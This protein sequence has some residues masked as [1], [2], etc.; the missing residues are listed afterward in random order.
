MALVHKE[1]RF[2]QHQDCCCQCPSHYGRPVLTQSSAGDPHTLTGKSGSVFC[3]VTVP[4]PS[5]LV[6]TGFAC[7]LQ[8]WSLFLLVLWSSYNQ[9][10]LAFKV[11]FP[12]DSQYL[13]WIPH[14]GSLMWGLEPSRQCEDFFGFIV[15]RFVGHPLSGYSVIA[16]R[17]GKQTH[18]E[19]QCR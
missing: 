12:W 9:V 15:L 16:T 11:R 8:E 7:V 6:H 1:P 10:P 14:L 19:G 5:V 17:S 18:S 2:W 4:F 13:G 3:G